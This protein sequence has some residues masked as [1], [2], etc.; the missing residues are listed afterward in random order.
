MLKWKKIDENFISIDVGKEYD[1][2][3]YSWTTFYYYKGLIIDS[4]CPH[5]AEESARFMEEMKLDVKA[6]LLT[7]YHEDHSGGVYLF[8]NRFDVNVFASEK[9]LEILARPPEIP[10][11]R[12]VVWGQPKPVEANPL[13]KKMTFNHVAIS[14]LETPGHSFDHVSFLAEN[15]LFMD[16]LVTSLTPIIIMKEEEYIDLIDSLKM[17]LTQSFETAYGGHGAWNKS[18]IKMALDNILELKEKIRNLRSDGLSAD[19]IVEKLFSHVPQKVLFMEEIS[20]CEW[21]RKNLVESMLGMRHK[22]LPRRQD[23]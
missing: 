12:Q 10:A 11:Y 7:H 17:I 20:E 1:G 6:V 15:I 5:T 13:K 3:P 19:Q 21:S 14:T 9:S 4:G 18:G 8:K 22:N 16:D 23:M 2:K